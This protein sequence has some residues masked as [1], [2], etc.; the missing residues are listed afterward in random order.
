MKNKDWW[1]FEKDGKFV[2]LEDK[3]NGHLHSAA[4]QGFKLVGVC[5]AKKPADAIDYITYIEAHKPM[6]RRK[7]S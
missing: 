6:K 7:K 5:A 4:L 1:V 2:A 3:H